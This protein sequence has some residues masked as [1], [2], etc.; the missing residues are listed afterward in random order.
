MFPLRSALS[1]LLCTALGLVST[2]AHAQPAREDAARLE[3]ARGL[4]RQVPLIDGHN[5]LPWQFRERVGNRLAALDLTQDG[6]KLEPPLHTDLRRLRE[7]GVGGVFWSVYVPA[8]LEGGAAIQATLEQIDVVHRL[9]ER[10]PQQLSL[11]LTADDVERAH[12]ASR[13]AS[14]IGMEGGHSIGGSLGV[15]RQMYRAGARYLTLTHSKNVPWAESATDAP[16]ATP[17]TEQ[18]RAVVREMNRLGMLVDLSH[19]SARTMN[20]VLDLSQAPVIF[21]HSSTFALDPHPRNVPDEVLRRLSKNGG[22]VMVTFVPGFISD[23]VRK[24]SAEESAAAERFKVLHAGN[25]DAAKAALT[26]WRSANPAPRATL[27]QVADHIDHVRKLA[28]I[29]SV[30]LGS[31]FDG[32]STTIQGLEGVE[33]Y[34]ALLAELLRRGYSDEDVRKV[35]G[36]NLLRVMRQAEATARRLQ[37][38][39]LAE[40]PPAEAEKPVAGAGK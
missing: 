39:R 9:V 14:L 17:L 33:T 3:R 2:R 26:A 18:G 5:D 11:A 32:I 40:D 1:L 36:K 13:V 12:R 6:R 27:A 25:P 29:D 8:D 10:Y 31:D 35:A 24:Y 38:E 16:M 4:L 20:A 7:G 30:G 34:P 28:G 21:S 19:V 22:L 23:E 15:L 37:K